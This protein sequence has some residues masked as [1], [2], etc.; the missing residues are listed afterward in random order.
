MNCRDFLIRM[1]AFIADELE[2]DQTRDFREHLRSCDSCRESAVAADPVLLL[3]ASPLGTASAK[4]VEACVEV[5]AALIH[6]DQLQRRI[7]R[8]RWRWMAAAAAVVVST[9]AGLTWWSSRPVIGMGGASLPPAAVSAVSY[10][11]DPPPPRVEVESPGGNLRV[12]QYAD[13]GDGNTTVVYIVKES[14]EL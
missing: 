4:Q 7:S 2:A 3:S 14:L 11:Q 9:G 8:P 1:D 10:Q 12:Y 13:A 5:V 6:Q